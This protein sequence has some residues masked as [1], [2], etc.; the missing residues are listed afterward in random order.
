[1]LE[2]QALTTEQAREAE[3]AAEKEWRAQWA[4]NTGRCRAAYPDLATY[5][6]HRRQ[7][8]RAQAMIGTR[9]TRGQR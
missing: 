4:S 3:A 5:L 8:F 7:E 2:S 6:S 9:Q 1:M